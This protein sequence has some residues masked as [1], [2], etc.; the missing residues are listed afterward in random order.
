MREH[1]FYRTVWYTVNGLLVL[2]I[3]LAMYS[4]GW[5]YSTRRYLKGFSDAIIPV[6]APPEEKIQAIL[7]WMSH[8]PTREAAGPDGLA[9]DR[10]PTETL[11]YHALLQV[12]GTATNAF[13]NLA[14]SGGLVPRRLLLLDSHRLA[15]HVAAEVLV[16]GRWIVVDP[17]FRVILRG[18][19]GKPLT[20]EQLENPTVFAAA[21]GKIRGYN[22]SYSYDLTVHVR[23]GRLRLIGFPIR[24]ILN[25]VLP[26]WEDSPV[27]SL[28]VERESFAVLLMSTG[29]VVLLV[30]LRISLRWYG[31]N[32]LGVHT[33]RMREQIRRAFGAFMD[34]AS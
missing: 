34:S 22:P 26:G 3:V 21:T 33:L 8:G 24:S 19:D 9:P 20:R 11:N 13:I 4:I 1:S 31:E 18:T 25:S 15:K 2:A 17:A 32:R 14:D 30:L 6:A 10:D 5:E 27:V 23:L 12:C 16:D 7:N 29:L 28:L